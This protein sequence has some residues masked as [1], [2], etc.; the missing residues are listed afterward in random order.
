MRSVSAAVEAAFASGE[1]TLVT[2]VEIE[3]PS[4]TV[5]LCS[6][7]WNIVWNGNTYLGA[8]G[9]GAIS[10][11]TDQPGEL[12]GIQLELLNADSATISLALDEADEVQDSPITISTAILGGEPLAVLDVVTDWV[13]YAD[14]MPIKEDGASSVIVLTA[15]SKG[16]D[17]LRGNPLTYSDADQ[18]SLYQFDFAFM[19]VNPQVDQP[20]I[21]PK[22]E[23]FFK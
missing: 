9:L 3:F 11:I 8:S 10:V 22:R 2:L 18:K 4:Q 13:G 12:P 20:V 5:Y 6:A 1:A 7:N 17:L 19:Y 15:E 16:V 23:W 14:T 21:W